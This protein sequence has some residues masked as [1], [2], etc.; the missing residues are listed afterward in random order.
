M[1]D[2]VR[3]W[4]EQGS[5][6]IFALLTA[7]IFVDGNDVSGGPQLLSKLL[8]NHG[9]ITAPYGLAVFTNS[10]ISFTAARYSCMPRI[11][12]SLWLAPE[13]FSNF[14]SPDGQASYSV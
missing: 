7:G 12:I 10:T 14:L 6:R 8:M 4:A 3:F 9:G 5:R 2:P 1:G 11:K 13:I